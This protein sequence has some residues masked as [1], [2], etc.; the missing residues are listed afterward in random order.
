MTALFALNQYPFA[1]PIYFLFIW[2]LVALLVI[3][4]AAAAAD[5]RS[6]AGSTA[7]VRSSQLLPAVTAVGGFVIFCMIR[8]G[9]P[10]AWVEVRVGPP[11]AEYARLSGLLVDRAVAEQYEHLKA[12]LDDVLRPDQTVL[13]GPDAPDVY[14]FTGRRNPTPVMFEM[15]VSPQDHAAMLR[16]LVESD[17]IGAVVFNLYPGFSEPWSEDVGRPLVHRMRRQTRIGKFIV[18]YDRAD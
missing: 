11:V 8:F 10:G 3:A 17:D 9:W 2:P 7:E 13:A 14:F 18:Y 15:F 6:L 4:L 12:L 16:R 5:G 1:S